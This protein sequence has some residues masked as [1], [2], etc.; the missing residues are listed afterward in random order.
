MKKGLAII[1]SL[2]IVA[3]ASVTLLANAGIMN[4]TVNGKKVHDAMKDG[5]KVNACNYC[6]G[7]GQ[8]EKKHQNLMKGQAAFGSLKAKPQCAGPACHR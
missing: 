5:K 2:C 8:I 4:F 6:H 1:S 3:F 7:V